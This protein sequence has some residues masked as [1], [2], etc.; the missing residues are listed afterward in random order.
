[1]SSNSGYEAEF[2]TYGSCRKSGSANWIPLFRIKFV[3]VSGPLG[4]T[5]L[6]GEAAA[7]RLCPFGGFAE[8]QQCD[9][10]VTL[11]W[12][13]VVSVWNLWPIFCLNFGAD[14]E[15]LGVL[16]ELCGADKEL[17]IA[18]WAQFQERS[19]AIE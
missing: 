3:E 10:L 11:I 18:S 19:V 9:I 12:N 1:M 5:E 8:E 15:H 2:C 7:G 14:A 6:Y 13:K 16:I 17:S 4:V